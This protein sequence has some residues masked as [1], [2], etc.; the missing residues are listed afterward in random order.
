MA[1]STI[2]LLAHDPRIPSLGPLRIPKL[3]EVNVSHG[4]YR[5]DGAFTNNSEAQI[6]YQVRLLC[7]IATSNETFF[8]TKLTSGIAVAMCMLNLSVFANVYLEYG[9]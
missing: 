4:P 1:L 5:I 7:G 2:V 8:T 9:H 3:E 6:V